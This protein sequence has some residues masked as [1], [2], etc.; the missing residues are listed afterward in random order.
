MS[1]KFPLYFLNLENKITKD[2]IPRVS[3]IVF[4]LVGRSHFG[5]QLYP[6]K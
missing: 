6:Q 1:I 3:V 5:I 4:K 2:P